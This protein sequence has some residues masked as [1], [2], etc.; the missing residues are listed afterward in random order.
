MALFATI[1]V[2]PVAGQ[3]WSP[4]CR[5]RPDNRQL[6]RAIALTPGS[7]RLTLVATAGRTAGKY[8]SGRLRLT[9]AG[10]TDRSPRTG[11]GPD[12]TRLTQFPLVGSVDL[13]FR[14]VGAPMAAAGSSRAPAPTST[15]PIYPGVLV[16]TDF[17]P[18][19]TQLGSARL[20]IGTLQNQRVPSF[21][22]DGMGIM[23]TVCN[24]SPI[25]FGGTWDRYGIVSNG[26]GYFC[27]DLE[28]R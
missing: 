27:A 3:A 22:Q 15:D 20:L 17:V 24:W 16:V 7:Y 18:D 8:R 4:P 25:G 23:L 10:P 21:A 9:L 6:G 2:G 12:T 19:S 5:P 11:E 26:S 14:G 28:E 1:L 13:D